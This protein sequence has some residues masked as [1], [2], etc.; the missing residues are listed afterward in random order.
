[1]KHTQFNSNNFF[2]LPKSCRLWGNVEEYG[3]VGQATENSKIRRMRFA[4]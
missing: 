4:R 1:M 3:T 2:F